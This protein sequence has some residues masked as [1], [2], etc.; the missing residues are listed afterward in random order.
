MLDRGE[1]LTMKSPWGGTWGDKLKMCAPWE[2]KGQSL[3]GSALG[4]WDLPSNAFW[5]VTSD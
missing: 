5:A 4:P 3:P 2:K 1:N